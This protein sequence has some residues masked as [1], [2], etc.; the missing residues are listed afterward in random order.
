MRFWSSQLNPRLLGTRIREA[1]EHLGISQGQLAELVSKDQ[2]AISAYEL[3]KRKLAAVDLPLFAK[4]LK[5]SVLDFYEGEISSD[6]L[7]RAL[8]SEFSKLPTVES[9]K[10]IITV[11][12]TVRETI[13]THYRE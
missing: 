9:K 3:G 5:V 8:L 13:D 4:V 1:R 7:D 6:D 11:V 10:A 2:A 12:R